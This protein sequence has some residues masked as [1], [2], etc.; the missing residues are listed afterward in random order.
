MT[1]LKLHTWLMLRNMWD[2]W[3]WVGGWDAM[4]SLKLHTW[5]MLRNMWWVG[6]WDVMTSLKLHTLLMPH[7]MCD[8]VWVGGGGM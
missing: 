5:L 4:T 3:G 2:Y 6:G 8:W 1:S 7:N